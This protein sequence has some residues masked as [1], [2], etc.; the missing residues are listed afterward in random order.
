M[1]ARPGSASEVAALRQVV[2]ASTPMVGC[3][4]YGE[5]APLDTASLAGRTVVQTGS[6]LVIAIGT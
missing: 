3:Y 6:V 5:Q 2:G 1:V 4:T